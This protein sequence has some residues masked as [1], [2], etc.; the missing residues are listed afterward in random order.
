[1][2]D[3]INQIREGFDEGYHTEKLTPSQRAV[4]VWCYIEVLTGFIEYCLQANDLPEII[5]VKE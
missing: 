1:L 4:F 5:V 2:R 3:T